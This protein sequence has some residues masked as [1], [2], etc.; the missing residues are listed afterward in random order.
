MTDSIPWVEKYRPRVLDDV[1]GNEETVARLRII[2]KE[3][4]LPNII[5]SGNLSY[6]LISLVISHT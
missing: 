5:L 6:I 4:N 3:G 1:I 2:A